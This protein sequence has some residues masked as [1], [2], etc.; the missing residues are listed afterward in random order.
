MDMHV[1][2]WKVLVEQHHL[3]KRVQPAGWKIEAWIA[4]TAALQAMDGQLYRIDYKKVKNHIT[5]F[6]ATYK[7][8]NQIREFSGFG[9]DYETQLFTA[10]DTVWSA[11]LRAHPTLKTF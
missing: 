2:F 5:Q 9:W 6:Q 11:L 3:G 4:V 8:W 1:V 10:D 7:K